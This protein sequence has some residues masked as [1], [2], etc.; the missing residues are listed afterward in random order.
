ML[1]SPEQHTYPPHAV[2]STNPESIEMR[3]S[4]DPL[5]ATNVTS[6]DA[7]DAE[8]SSSTTF[9]DAE[10]DKGVYQHV[11]LDCLWDVS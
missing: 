1:D 10:V 11:D 7:R 5:V 9:S 3:A 4:L 6:Y 2:S 8:A